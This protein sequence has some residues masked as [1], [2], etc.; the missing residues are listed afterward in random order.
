MAVA[1]SK[2]LQVVER[3]A[4]D[5]ERRRAQALALS[6]RRVGECEAKLEELR[7]YYANYT[8]ELAELSRAGIGAAR[9]REFQAFLARLDEAIRQQC[10]IL[11][12]AQAERD[13]A[14]HGW[15]HAAQRAEIIGQ[16]V[17]RRQSEERRETERRDQRD[18]D[19]RAQQS[20]TRKNHANRT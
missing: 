8:H 9:L 1:K 11:A 3:V 12:R 7:R 14:R 5:H 17:K 4:D 2:R 19:E 20:S 16:V 10:D 6:E 18:S 13:G 15:Q